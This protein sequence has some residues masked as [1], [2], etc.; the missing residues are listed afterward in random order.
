MP[1]LLIDLIIILWYKTCCYIKKHNDDSR[2]EYYN[3]CN[4]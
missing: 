4:S 3:V 1:D 2:K